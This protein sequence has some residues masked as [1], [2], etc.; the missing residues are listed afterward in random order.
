VTTGGIRRGLLGFVGGG[1]GGERVALT[2]DGSSVV[3][4]MLVVV[5]KAKTLLNYKYKKSGGLIFYQETKDR[6]KENAAAKYSLLR[7]R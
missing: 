5:S 4:A 1:G 2:T 6:M 3:A 7:I